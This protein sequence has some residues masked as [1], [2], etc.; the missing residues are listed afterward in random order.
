MPLPNQLLQAVAAPGGGRLALVLGAGCS[1]EAPTSLPSGSAAAQDLHRLL[2]AD[3]VLANGDVED[4]ND[5]SAVADAVFTKTRSQRQLVERFLDRYNLKRANANTGYLVVAAM[6]CEQV[7]SSVVTLNFDLALVDALVTL[8]VG[9]EVAVVEKPADL[10]NQA[11]INVYYLHRNAN[12]ADPDQWLL[13]TAALQTEWVNTWQP[14]VAN[15]VLAAPVVVFAGLGT[16]I[17]VLI[18]STKLLKNAIPNAAVY[19]VDMVPRADSRFA[20]ELGINDAAYVESGWCAFMD[21]L[22]QRLAGE[23]TQQL[24]N[25]ANQKVQDD[26]LAPEDVTNLLARLAALGLVASGKIRALWLLTETAYCRATADAHRLVA[27]LLLTVA[28]MAR[29]SGTQAIIAEDGVVEFHR[30]GRV[31]AACLL[32]SGRGF[33]GRPS[34]EAAVEHQRRRHRSRVV[35]VSAAVVGGTSD[36]TAPGTPPADLVRGDVEEDILL[37]LGRLSMHHVAELRADANKIQEV[38][39]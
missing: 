5:L 33:R 24:S 29:V 18:E 13:R 6:L 20:K 7:I 27:D 12:A 25:A 8:G 9:Q 28:A 10:G 31:S 14:I 16:P 36:W 26:G 17:A 1:M 15:R 39:R 23:H 38:I 22:A 4:P 21:D 32:A 19:Q 3:G 2:V 37:G 35:P 11:L 30:D 34:M